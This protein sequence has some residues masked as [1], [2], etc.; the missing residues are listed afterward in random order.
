MNYSIFKAYGFFHICLIS[1]S[2]ARLS[3]TYRYHL[4]KHFFFSNWHLTLMSL[5]SN[6]RKYVTISESVLHYTQFLTVVKQLHSKNEQHPHQRKETYITLPHFISTWD[7]P[8]AHFTTGLPNGRLTAPPDGSSNH[9][10]VT[11]RQEYDVKNFR[12]NFCYTMKGFVT[13][14]FRKIL[15]VL[16]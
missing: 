12:Y 5:S 3:L 8:A 4:R 7:T 6:T 2:C 15:Y 14:C 16:G 11:F 10:A 1:V 13:F 9:S